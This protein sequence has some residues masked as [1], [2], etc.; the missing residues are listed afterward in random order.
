MSVLESW[1]TPGVTRGVVACVRVYRSAMIMFKG[2]CDRLNL[3]GRQVDPLK[4]R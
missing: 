3:P 4:E 2:K 1:V